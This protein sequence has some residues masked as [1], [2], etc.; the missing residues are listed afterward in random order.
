MSLQVIGR[1][2]PQSPAVVKQ[3]ESFTATT[4][5]I[6]IREQARIMSFRF[7]SN[8]MD[9]DYQMGSPLALVQDG[10]ERPA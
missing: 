4:E 1:K 8:E 10:D 2:Y 9:G 5:K 7:E 3:E 6:D